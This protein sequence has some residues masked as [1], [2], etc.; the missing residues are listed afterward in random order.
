MQTQRVAPVVAFQ[1]VYGAYS[2]AA[3]LEAVPGCQPLP[4]EHFETAFQ[5]HRMPCSLHAVSDLPILSC[6]VSL[7]SPCAGTVSSVVGI[8]LLVSDSTIRCFCTGLFIVVQASDGRNCC[9]GAGLESIGAIRT[10]AVTVAG[11]QG[12]PSHREQC[13][14]QHTCGV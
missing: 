2:E 11:G 7:D 4:C 14:R 8:L 13:A 3:A 6:I 1:G 9:Q 12:H 10:G 5:V